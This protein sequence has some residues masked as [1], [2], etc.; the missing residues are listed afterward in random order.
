M[1]VWSRRNKAEAIHVTFIE[2]FT[3]QAGFI[4]SFPILVAVVVC[5]KQVHALMLLLVT[6]NNMLLSSPNRN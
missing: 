2:A 1:Q 3:W 4:L 6:T 5:V